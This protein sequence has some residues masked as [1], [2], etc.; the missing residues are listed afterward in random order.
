[1]AINKAEKGRKLRVLVAVESGWNGSVSNHSDSGEVSQMILLTCIVFKE[2]EWAV[3]GI[4]MEVEGT[5]A[6]NLF[7]TSHIEVS[8]TVE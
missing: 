3:S 6:E 4:V 8:G 5:G 7:G 2:K 1:M